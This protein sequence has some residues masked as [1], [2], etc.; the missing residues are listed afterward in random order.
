MDAVKNEAEP[1]AKKNK[2]ERMLTNTTI[3]RC[4]VE[5]PSCR[6]RGIRLSPSLIWARLYLGLLSIQRTNSIIMRCVTNIK[7][8]I[9]YSTTYLRRRDYLV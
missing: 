4:L 9:Q 5:A 1:P 3:L 6:I 7:S 8:R 2:F